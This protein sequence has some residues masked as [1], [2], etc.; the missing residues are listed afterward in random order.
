M[1]ESLTNAVKHG[2][3]TGELTIDHTAGGVRIEV[4]NPVSGTGPASSGGGH[5]L[6]GMR[7]RVEAVHGRLATGLGPDGVFTL[8]AEIPRDR[9]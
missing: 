9:P 3:G 7:E 2:S 6:I 1:Q 8:S 5:G 4:R